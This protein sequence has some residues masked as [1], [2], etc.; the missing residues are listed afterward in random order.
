M[1]CCE[2]ENCPSGNF[3]DKMK[4]G[5]PFVVVLPTSKGADAPFFCCRSNPP[6][7]W[8]SRGSCGRWF[9]RHAFCHRVMVLYAVLMLDDLAVQ[10]V[11]QHVN[12]GIQVM[13]NAFGMQVLTLNVNV[14]FCFLAFFFFCQLVD[15]EDHTDVDDVIE[16]A[17]DTRQFA[18]HVFADCR[19]Q[20]EVM[21]TN[22]QIHTALLS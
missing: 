12:G 14:D 6:A 7:S 8:I 2:M 9:F 21:A 3:S 10:F 11:D 19:G 15:A 18:L 20:I 5:K 16:M 4:I 17:L 1:R 22:G 13:C